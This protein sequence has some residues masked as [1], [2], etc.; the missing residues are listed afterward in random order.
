MTAFNGHGS[1]ITLS[2]M[3]QLAGQAG[4]SGASA[5]LKIVDELYDVAKDFHREASHFNLSTPL[6]TTIQREIDSQWR[7]LRE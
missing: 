4:L 6:I 3:D 5:V 7:Q 2:A 1:R